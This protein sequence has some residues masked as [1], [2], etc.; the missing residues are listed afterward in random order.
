MKINVIIQKFKPESRSTY[1]YMESCSLLFL[2]V[3][4]MAVEQ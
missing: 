4:G 2:K 3:L 1:C